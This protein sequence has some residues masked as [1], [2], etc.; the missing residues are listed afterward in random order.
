MQQWPA[1]ANVT[2]RFLEPLS[3]PLDPDPDPSPV[4]AGAVA[5]RLDGV[6]VRVAGRDVL[7]EVDLAIGAG[8]HV[9]VVGASGAGK[10]TLAGLL[11]GWHRP[12]GGQVLVDGRP[13]E[14]GD[15]V[16]LRRRTAWVDPSVRLWNTSLTENIAYGNPG[17]PA[18]ELAA[19]SCAVGL[20]E[21]SARL[22]VDPRLAGQVTL[23][24]AGGLLSGGEGQR[25]RLARALARPGVGLAVLDEPFRGLER[26]ARTA[27]LEVCR[28]RWAA[29]TL[30]CITHDVADTLGLDRVLVIDAGRVLEDGRPQA[31]A[32]DPHSAYAAL[33][34]AAQATEAAWSDPVWRRL[35][36]AA[37]TVHEQPA[38][39]KATVHS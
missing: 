24:E 38:G 34:A 23:G 13:R 26:T 31:L 39:Q 22:S 10:S 36:L 5:L 32:A 27:L 19:V 18:A 29:A 4:A 11:L 15:L 3:A 16:A 1:Q 8:E 21:V 20:D 35:H 2:L 9:G 12:A 28:R 33:L 7:H 14:A 17:V 25:V 6:T 30:I 37:G